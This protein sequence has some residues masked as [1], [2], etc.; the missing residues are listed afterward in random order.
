MERE[1]TK[2]ERGKK[3]KK[4]ERGGTPPGSSS[5]HWDGRNTASLHPTTEPTG[6]ASRSGGGTRFE[7]RARVHS[8]PPDSHLVSSVP[9][10]VPPITT[11]TTGGRAKVALQRQKQQEEEEEFSKTMPLPLTT[12]FNWDEELTDEHEELWPPLAVQKDSLA[13]GA[14]KITMSAAAGDEGQSN[15]N[16]RAPDHR[17]NPTQRERAAGLLTTLPATCK[18][19]SYVRPFVGSVRIEGEEESRDNQLVAGLTSTRTT[20]AFTPRS[21]LARAPLG[22][23]ERTFRS[24]ISCTGGALRCE[25]LGGLEGRV[26][27][28]RGGVP[29]STAKFDDIVTPPLS[30][31]KDEARSFSI[32]RCSDILRG[33]ARICPGVDTS[34]DTEGNRTPEAVSQSPTV[35]VSQPLVREYSYFEEQ[36]VSI[37]RGLGEGRDFSP[38]LPCQGMV[39]EGPGVDTMTARAEGGEEVGSNSR[40]QRIRDRLSAANANPLLITLPQ[41]PSFSPVT[42]ASPEASANNETDRHSA[43][44]GPST[45]LSAVSCR[46][47][48]SRHP[49]STAMSAL[50][51]P[52]DK[53]WRAESDTIGGRGSRTPQQI[54][55]C[56]RKKGMDS[57]EKRKVLRKDNDHPPQNGSVISRPTVLTG[58]NAAEVVSGLFIGSYA[59]SKRPEVLAERGISLV[60]NVATEC[61]VTPEMLNNPC[62]VHYMKF[63]M[64]DNSDEDVARYL[65]SFAQLIHTQLHR[66][67]F[68][69][70]R[71]E[72]TPPFC[73]H[74]TDG[75]TNCCHSSQCAAGSTGSNATKVA[76]N[77]AVGTRKFG[78]GA[79]QGMVGDGN[80]GA[81]TCHG[82]TNA[83]DGCGGSNKPVASSTHNS[84][85]VLPPMFQSWGAGGILVHC[86]EGVSRSATI[87]LGYLILYGE[88]LSSNGC[89]GRIS[90]EVATLIKEA[91]N[92]SAPAVRD[93]SCAPVCCGSALPP[94]THPSSPN[95]AMIRA[96]NCSFSPRRGV[97]TTTPAAVTSGSG[98]P[99]TAVGASSFAVYGNDASNNIPM[100]A[101]PGTSSNNNG[102]AEGPNVGKNDCDVIA[103]CACC[104]CV[105]R[106]SVE[107]GSK[108]A[109][110]YQWAFEML[111]KK[112]NI[113][114]NIGF[115]LALQALAGE[116]ASPH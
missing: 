24:N 61:A 37:N 56:K 25:A 49:S 51:G 113:S 116:C 63:H 1:A 41:S 5:D 23:N 66:R 43:P 114:P 100:S 81:A 45:T 89:W 110:S 105:A 109:G 108:T 96:G 48:L 78:K 57:G 40:W 42:A 33:G 79:E 103:D 18:T 65:V 29:R 101:T 82:A 76:T 11:T 112:R 15:A 54:S 98:S 84:N 83:G 36:S 13:T 58:F 70:T 55:P 26:C 3:G 60:I 106:R 115:V 10:H 4:N 86:R 62:N 14:Q 34:E 6:R 9:L 107:E 20:S 77:G 99:S 75:N 104:C 35:D 38:S 52:M 22:T 69:L 80:I 90:D 32:G 97:N 68:E 64:K 94:S 7:P 72:T 88:F 21:P 102:G 111:R 59:D 16:S 85:S 92:H 17:S 28:T 95:G 53:S 46:L 2:R 47:D 12:T 71:T 8:L 74:P 31:G 50:T 93:G 73:K 39:E 30:V 91:E 67:Q 19:T 27:N 87:V 44:R